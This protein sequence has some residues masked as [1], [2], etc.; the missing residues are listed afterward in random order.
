M[1]NLKHATGGSVCDTCIERIVVYTQWYVVALVYTDSSEWFP[2]G[3][4]EVYM[5]QTTRTEQHESCFIAVNAS[6]TERQQCMQ[7]INNYIVK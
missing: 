1:Q 7:A 4:G 2:C 6:V 3:N 5:I